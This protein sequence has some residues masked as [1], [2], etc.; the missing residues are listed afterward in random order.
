MG[1]G[2]W[3][4]WKQERSIDDSSMRGSASRGNLDQEGD[5][6]SAIFPLWLALASELAAFTADLGQFATAESGVTTATTMAVTVETV[7]VSPIMVQTTLVTTYVPADPRV[8][9]STSA[10]STEMT[11]SIETALSGPTSSSSSTSTLLTVTNYW[12]L[13]STTSSIQ[14][15]TGGNISTNLV[16]GTS[17]RQ[18][19]SSPPTLPAVVSATS[20][21]LP[22]TGSGTLPVETNPPVDKPTATASGIPITQARH[23]HR[24]AIIGGLAGSIA[25]LL[26]IGLLVF[27]IMRKRRRKDLNDPELVE[28]SDE[29]G[30]RPAIKRK[31]TELTGKGT[32]KQTPQ[33]TMRSPVTVDEEHHIIRMSTQH[34]A[35]PYA[36]GQGEGFR[37]SML[38]GTLR[39]TNPDMSRPETPGSSTDTAGKFLRKQRSALAAALL[40]TDRPRGSSRSISGVRTPTPVPDV[41]VDP[42][43]SR[44]CIGPTAVAPFARS[45]FSASTLAVV[46][47]QPPEDPFVTPPDE[48]EEPAPAKSQPRRPLLTPIQSASTAAQRT[49]SYLGSFVLSM[50]TRSRDDR[51]FSNHSVSTF[52]SASS[53]RDT[54]YSDPFDLDRPSARGSGAQPAASRTDI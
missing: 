1:L 52:T 29:K 43:S 13:S 18:T 38:P 36:A 8:Q 20:R 51:S 30:I 47:Q 41:A 12:T 39:V 42:V 33:M 17:V 37:D 23:I 9:S 49:F 53:Q 25:G 50:R 11:S 46:H 27:L 34:W 24:Q 40:N 44:E 19:T 31:L 16:T 10:S 14:P 22:L 28:A 5:S 4:R 6:P 35:R 32:P 3:Y 48:R 54:T 15:N 7:T 21:N 45:H 26:L 2:L